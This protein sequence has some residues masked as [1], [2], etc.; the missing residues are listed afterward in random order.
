VF[1]SL[2]WV[3]NLLAAVIHDTFLL[4]RRSQLKRRSDF[5]IRKEQAWFVERKIE[6]VH[7]GNYT[8]EHVGVLLLV[9]ATRPR[10]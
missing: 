1:E 9:P 6:A 10:S 4:S 2:L 5:K 3:L 8:T 7:Y